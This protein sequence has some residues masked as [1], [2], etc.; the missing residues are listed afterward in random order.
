MK[1]NAL[2][3]SNENLSTLD[4]DGIVSCQEDSTNELICL[5]KYVGK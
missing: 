3:I 5:Y 4:R 2:V 1:F